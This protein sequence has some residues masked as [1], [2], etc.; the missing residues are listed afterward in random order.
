[1]QLTRS[2]WLISV[3]LFQVYPLLQPVE[4]SSQLQITTT[5]HQKTSQSQVTTTQSGTVSG[6]PSVTTISQ[7]DKGN[8]TSTVLLSTQEYVVSSSTMQ[9]VVPI[10]TVLPQNN[11]FVPTY[12]FGGGSQVY[13]NAAAML[14][15]IA[16][17]AFML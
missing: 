1:M 12:T 10:S 13:T 16:C 17:I 2:I 8:F 15:I 9:T 5:S 7:A 4:T 3:V 6:S 14:S 11:T